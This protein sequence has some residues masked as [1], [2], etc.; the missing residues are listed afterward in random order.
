MLKCYASMATVHTWEVEQTNRT[1]VELDRVRN[2]AGRL[3]PFFFRS[4]SG[5]KIKKIFSRPGGYI[6]A[7]SNT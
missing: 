4:W 7:K 3:A 1:R 6:T 5:E 2:G